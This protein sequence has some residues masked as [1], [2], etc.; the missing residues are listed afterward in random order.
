MVTLLAL[1]EILPVSV[2]LNVPLPEA[3]LKAIVVALVGLAGLP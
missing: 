3:L 1:V 2:P